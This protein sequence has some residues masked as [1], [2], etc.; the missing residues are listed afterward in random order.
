MTRTYHV[1]RARGRLV[2][3]HREIYFFSYTF[4]VHRTSITG[5]KC[6]N[7]IIDAWTARVYRD[8][9]ERFAWTAT[10]RDF[11]R[12]KLTKEHGKPTR[13]FSLSISERFLT[14]I[15]RVCVAK[16]GQ[17]EFFNNS[18]ELTIG[19]RDLISWMCSDCKIHSDNCIKHSFNKKSKK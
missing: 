6:K 1:P 14:R 5:R 11:Y 18:S 12:K 13:L 2:R 16:I 7:F 17:S 19:I 3:C 4:N 8:C 10:T 15:D 9:A